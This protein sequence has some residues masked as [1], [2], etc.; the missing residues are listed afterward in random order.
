MKKM[1]YKDGD[2]RKR[3]KKPVTE[4]NKLGRLK[5]MLGRLFS[6]VKRVGLKIE[7]LLAKIPVIKKITKLNTKKKRTAY[8]ALALA[9]IVPAAYALN[10]F[11]FSKESGF[12]YTEY[13]VKKGNVEDTISGTGTVTPIKQYTVR[14]LVEGDVLS[15]TF[16]EGDTVQKGDMLYVV[17]AEEMENSLQ[18]ANIA[19]EKQQMSYK[20]SLEAYAGLA[21][22]SPIS[23]MI[24]ELYVAKGDTVQSGTKIAKVVDNTTMTAQI[25]FSENDAES[26]Y[27][28]ESVTV[29]VENTFEQLTGKI[30]RIYNSK[31]VLDGYITVTDVD[32]TVNNPGYLQTGTYVS[33][34]ANGIACY[35]PGELEASSEKIVTAKTSGTISKISVE[36]A[37]LKTGGQIAVLENDDASDEL[38]SSQLSLQESQLSYNTTQKQLDNY[39]ITAPISGSVISKTAKAGDTIDSDTTTEMCVIADMST[40][41]FEMSVDELDIASMKVGQEVSITA[42]ALADKTFT[43]Y[44]DNIGLLGTATDGVTSYPVTIVINDGEGL[45][46][47]MNV[48]GEIV[49][50]SA[51]D[52]LMIPVDAVNRGDTVLVKE[53]GS[54]SSGSA[55]NAPSAGGEETHQN[56]APDG[57][58]YVKVS[59]GLNNDSY[60]E[61]TGGLSEGMV[62]LVPKLTV[63]NSSS[64]TKMQ[65]SAMG[66]GMQGGGMQGGGTP[67]SGGGRSG[68][69]GAP[70]M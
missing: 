48:T 57:Y 31:R 34:T 2:V 14:C 25:P 19:L 37:Y 42:D 35:S 10:T 3:G 29:T 4:S 27:V 50:D 46:P 44:V 33:A 5:K 58:K 11:A 60:I 65:G 23:G 40:I 47:G 9:V 41:T 30:S 67:P 7:T 13:T 68:G 63:D 66:G 16:E 22:T 56:N 49:V 28:G 54:V 52:V 69:G 17:D 8:V 6:T 21:V 36:G 32:V 15:D 1:R 24:D 45:W 61:V 18:K 43:G 59:L 55:T 38:K 53:T 39:T 62:I 70:G 51:E 20:N 26:L 12:N 64:N